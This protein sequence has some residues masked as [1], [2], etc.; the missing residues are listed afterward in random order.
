MYSNRDLSSMVCNMY[1]D[2]HIHINW[3][4]DNRLTLESVPV[5]SEPK[6]NPY[7]SQIQA[8]TVQNHT[9]ILNKGGDKSIKT[10]SFFKKQLKVQLTDSKS[11]PSKVIP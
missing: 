6:P 3:I 9:N 2:N 8:Q 10:I 7:Q 5:N 4:I 11:Q 1:L